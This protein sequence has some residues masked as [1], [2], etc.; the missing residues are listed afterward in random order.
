MEYNTISKRNATHTFTHN[1]ENLRHD[2]MSMKASAKRSYFT[3][4]FIGKGYSW[5][6]TNQASPGTQ[7][8]LIHRTEG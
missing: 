6:R 1:R 3:I 2:A 5:K 8:P 4:S 7:G